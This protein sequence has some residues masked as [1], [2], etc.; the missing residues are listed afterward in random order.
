MQ[1][2]RKR[3]TTRIAAV[4]LAA[5]TLLGLFYLT[6]NSRV[7]TDR[8]KERIDQ[9]ASERI[10]VP[11]HTSRIS[12]TFFPSFSVTLYE[13]YPDPEKAALSPVKR[14]DRIKVSLS[15]F[16]LFAK[17]GVI[18]SVQ[19]DR[20]VLYLPVGPGGEVGL[21]NVRQETREGTARWWVQ[22]IE[23]RE[24]RIVLQKDPDT[25]LVFDPVQLVALTDP[26]T[27]KVWV[28]A[29]AS[30]GS[31]RSPQAATPIAAVETRFTI[32]STGWEI[33]RLFIQ[34]PEGTLRIRGSK[35]ADRLDLKLDGTVPLRIFHLPGP[36]G[37]W[38]GR[39]EGSGSVTGSLADFRI[40]GQVR[41]ADLAVDQISLGS[42]STSLAYGGRRFALSD[43]HGQI[44][45]GTL[46]GDGVV[47]LDP[48][49][50]GSFQLHIE[51]ARI[52][53]WVDRYFP[54][55]T[56]AA[57]LF[58]ATVRTE[59]S[60]RKF[61]MRTEGDFRLVPDG[62]SPPGTAR[63]AVREGQGRFAWAGQIL[64]L[65]DLRLA[66]DQTVVSCEVAF[67]L[68]RNLTEGSA[69]VQTRRAIEIARLFQLPLDGTADLEVSFQGMQSWPDL[70]LTGTMQRASFRGQPLGT[71]RTRFRI[72]QK[73]LV[74]EQAEI[75]QGAAHYDFA[76]LIDMTRAG[77]PIYRID[78]TVREGRP[79]QVLHL[80]TS[81]IPLDAPGSGLVQVR[82]EPDRLRVDADLT[83]GAGRAGPQLFDSGR[84]R[85]EL[86]NR[87]VT[88]HEAELVRGAT[89]AS[90]SGWFDFSRRFEVQG[91]ITPLRI[92]DLLPDLPAVQ[93]A[94]TVTFEGGGSW[95]DP[96][97]RL[98]GNI[99]GL[100]IAGEPYGDA[101]VEA[102]LSRKRLEVSSRFAG[103]EA[104]GSLR[105]ERGWEANVQ[106]HLDRLPVD[107]FLR[108]VYSELSP[109]DHLRA[110]GDLQIAI[111]GR[112]PFR[113]SG[114]ILLDRVE[115]DLDGYT[116][117]NEGRV[118]LAL[119]QGALKVKALQLRGAGTYLAVS[120]GLEIGQ[121]FDL[122]LNGEMDL[123]AVRLFTNE[124][125]YGKGKAYVALKVSD[126]WGD[127]KFQGGITVQ[128]G[129][130]R[131]ESLGQTV[132]VTGGLFFN[133]HQILLE[134]FEL[135]LGEGKIQASGKV[136]LRN[137][138][139]E[140]VDLLTELTRVAIRPRRGGR[141]TVGGT[142]LLQGKPGKRSLTGEVELLEGIY[143]QRIELKTWLT[144]LRAK[145]RGG[146]GRPPSPALQALEET[147]LH[148]R[149]FGKE[150]IRIDNN[151][152]KIPLEVDLLIRGSLAKPL[153]YGRIEATGGTIRFRN[154]PFR[155]QSAALDF[156]DPEEIRPIVDIRAST[157]VS[158]YSIDLRLSG[159]L[160]RLD[161][162]LASSPPLG[163]TD[164]LA[165]LTV[166]KTT[167]DLVN[168]GQVGTGAAASFFV[169]GFLEGKVQE[170]TGLDTF[171]VEPDFG[172]EKGA[173]TPRLTVGKRLADDRLVVTYSTAL[174]PSQEQLIRLEYQLS[175]RVALVGRRDELGMSGDIR[176][177]LEFR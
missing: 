151:L 45:N 37:R 40:T 157:E 39:V 18:R 128:E 137:F 23:L 121:N 133:E 71:V 172:G 6:L 118:E 87:R 173:G 139:P 3:S 146:E 13:I 1:P 70:T 61:G 43:I 175:D 152:A 104:K 114:F 85:L 16:S 143:D 8:V 108:L 171:Q 112:N 32:R 17:Q 41:A 14:I 73:I 4:L 131:S 165:L 72:E 27:S 50:G 134:S 144:E 2:I 29:R 161:L 170:I 38:I 130:L 7:V 149:L 10:G 163:Q 46:S 63:L 164:I 129:E 169:E 42:V 99:Q 124:I 69:A 94:G 48:E 141:Y 60:F 36:P 109:R 176:L 140:Q 116:F 21:P 34:I 155:I 119:D 148:V 9:A 75:E 51:G 106:A 47:L 77:H 76:G 111:P 68:V 145:G 92:P 24:A 168:P 156:V 81:P 62:P 117:G 53:P 20:P 15:P 86:A 167:Q 5:I 54:R 101:T 84:V 107:P 97:G 159:P 174:D 90:L 136:E 65:R 26:A 91:Q 79:N 22:R 162:A 52:D 125:S 12:L 89:R 83:L 44:L 19:M 126:R 74:F 56:T 166:G 103:L 127:P 58:A 158:P 115:A 147:R 82:G 120:G 100:T 64:Q 142:L 33:D 132:I 153:L 123:D 78:T 93:G 160:D 59:G 66:N 98:S 177:R 25:E 154:N 113:P 96:S 28:D 35:V 95:D 122:F 55:F 88:F 105:I 11:I 80:F 150:N 57:T 102:D 135:G 30:G 49:P 31:L 67:D 110:S 138:R